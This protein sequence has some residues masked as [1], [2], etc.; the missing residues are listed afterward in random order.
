MRNKNAWID[1]GVC[2]LFGWLGVHK[3]RERRVGMGILYLLTFGLFFIGWAIDAVRY[4]LAALRGEQIPK[5][6]E[7]PHKPTKQLLDTDPLPTVIGHNL[8]LKEGERCHYTDT[9][10]YVKTKNVIIGYSGGNNGV[11]I[12]IAKGVSY[13]VGTSKAAPIRGNVEERT[14]GTLSITNHRIIFSAAKGSFDK[15]ISALTSLNPYSNAVEFQFGS[16]QYMLETNEAE[17]ITQVIVRIIN[18]APVA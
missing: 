14:P 2:V 4:L 1:F 7:M 17:Y 12:R 3:F 9:A 6:G 15:K 5:K 10:T 11:S 8:I 16:Q 13:R 18:T